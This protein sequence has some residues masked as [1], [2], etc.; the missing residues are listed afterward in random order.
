[1]K[2][3]P[4]KLSRAPFNAT[5]L[6]LI[7]YNRLSYLKQLV[8]WLENAGYQNIQIVDNASSYPPL[9]EYLANTPHTVHSMN[10]NYGHLVVWKSGRF[11]E[12]IKSQ[13][14]VVTDCDVLP[15]EGCPVDIVERCFEVLERYPGFT[16]VGPALK[17]DDIP[18]H[19]SLKDKVIDWETPFWAHPL[20]DAT[21]YEAAIDTT[22]ALY[23]PGIFA[24]DER[25][26]RAIRLATPYLARHLPW[27]TDGNAM[28]DEDLFYQRS[29]NNFSSQW[30]IT[31]P[32][33]LKEENMRLLSQLKEMQAE[34]QILR[35][36]YFRY[37]LHKRRPQIRAALARIG[38]VPLAKALERLIWS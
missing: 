20:E 24:G 26:W 29:L 21:L 35:S 4:K 27:Y 38:M 33:L 5:P 30:S 28:S 23:R 16:K 6:L 31:E 13:H 15:A 2:A 14:Y 17:I 10:Q 32:G 19:Y 25:W 37:Q 36:G 18:D 8:S 22:F 12:L 1:M 11:D 34:L 7:S 3:K 9:L